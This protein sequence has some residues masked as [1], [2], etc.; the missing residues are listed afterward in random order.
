MMHKETAPVDQTE[1]AVNEA[2]TGTAENTTTDHI[3]EALVDF[4][5]KIEHERLN[6]ACALAQ[7][8]GSSPADAVGFRHDLRN[9]RL[10]GQEIGRLAF[11]ETVQ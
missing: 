5:V 1:A 3:R 2:G 7:R 6:R 9:L 8:F 4:A 10:L 11:R